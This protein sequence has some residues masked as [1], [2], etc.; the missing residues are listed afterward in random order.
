[1]DNGTVTATQ[2]R[3]LVQQ[4][5][6][7]GKKT[8]KQYSFEPWGSVEI[9]VQAFAQAIQTGRVERRA[10]PEEALA[11]L[12]VVQAMLESGEDGGI[13]SLV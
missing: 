12:R 13:K 6:A 11:D 3:I 8:V 1:M 7:N 10:S 9:E 4:D 2:D 5:D